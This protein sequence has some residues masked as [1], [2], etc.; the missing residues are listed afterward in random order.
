MNVRP[1]TMN[2]RRGS[3]TER[4]HRNPGDETTMKL[5]LSTAL[6][7]LAASCASTAP[8]VGPDQSHDVAE[9][10]L[11]ARRLHRAGA[12]RC[13]RGRQSRHQDRADQPAARRLLHV[14]ADVVGDRAGSRHRRDVGR[15]LH[16][17]LRAVHGRPE[18]V[19]RRPTSSQGRP[20]PTTSARAATSTTRSTSRR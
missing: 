19:H 20:A 1:T 7:A 8:A 5:L 13:L 16:A 11:P 15:P 14:A 9:R 2:C 4:S 3:Q 12:G 6:A 18:A 10:R 17:R